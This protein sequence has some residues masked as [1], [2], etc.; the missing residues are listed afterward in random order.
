MF[1]P[2]TLIS[3]Y[4]PAIEDV[5]KLNVSSI[6][7]EIEFATVKPQN[8]KY[9]SINTIS[10]NLNIQKEELYTTLLSEL[11]K[12]ICEG[13]EHS[14]VFISFK[15]C[16]IDKR[17]IKKVIYFLLSDY[18]INHRNNVVVLNSPPENIIDE[19]SD[20]VLALNDALKNYKIHPLPIIDFDENGKD[21][22]VKWLGIYDDSD[23]KKLKDLLFEQYS[24]AQSDF[25]DPANVVGQL[26]DFDTYGNF[27]SNFPNRDDIISF[28]KHENDIVA[29]QQ[30]ESLL[31][32]YDCIKKDDDSLYLCN[33]NYY[34]KE[35]VELSNLLNDKT[36]CDTVSKLLFDKLKLNLDN[37]SNYKF[38]GITTT[39]Q[40]ILKSLETQKLISCD[41]YDP[42]LDNYHSFERDLT[43]EKIDNSKKY[44]LICDVISTGYLTQRLNSRLEKFNTNIEYVA[45]IASILDPNFR[46]T[47][48]FLDEFKSKLFSL[49]EFSIQ[50][51]ERTD[52]GIDFFKKKIVRVNPHT[53]IPIRLSVSET[54]FNESIALHTS[55][56]YSK[57]EN[58]ITVRNEFLNSIDENT[59][60]IGFYRFNNVIHPYF[61]N[62]KQILKELDEK[63]LKRTFEKINNSGFNTEKIKVFF[64]RKS[65]IDELNFK[66]LK[67]VLKNQHIEEIEIERFGTTEGWRFP[68]NTDYFSSK[69][70]DSFCF[71]LDDGSCSGDSLIQMIDEI[72]FYDAKEIVLLCFIGRVND[73]KR[74]FFSR[75]SQI[76][77]K[78]GRNIPISI[79]FV[80][81]WHIPT[82]Y[83]DDNPNT[84]ETNW[85][86]QINNLQN[87]PRIIKKIALSI[88]KEIKPKED[89]KFTDYKY[90][91][92]I[93]G[94]NKIPKKELLIIREE[95][96][97]VIG[98]RLYT[99][100]FTYFDYF[101]RK[102]QQPNKIAN[103]YQD[104]ELICAALVYE[105]YLY[106]KLIHILPDVTERIESFVSKLILEPKNRIYPLLT[107]NWREKD[108]LHL[109]FIVF[110]NEKLV[111]ILNDKSKFIRLIEFS[112]KR[113]S[114][115]NYIL[116][117]LL[118][119]LPL[120]I[121]EFKDKKYDFKIREII[122]SW[123]NDTTNSNKEIKQFYY[124]INSL[125]SRDDFDSQLEVLI[126]N[127]NK[128]KEPEFHVDKISFSH[129][130]S[131]ILAI[132]RGFINNIEEGN[133]LDKDK[134]DSI[135]EMWF[136]IL[137]F[138]NPIISFSK[139]F[140]DYLLPFPYF[141][142]Q[143]IVEKLISNV[144]YNEDVIFSLTESFN[145]SE[146]LKLVEK[147]ILRI[148]NDFK[149][150]S[151]FYN[152]IS[153]RQ[154]NLN[155]LLNS[156]HSEMLAIPK[157]IYCT[158]EDLLNDSYT[159]NLPEVYSELLIRKELI[160]NIKNHSKKGVDSAVTIYYS[161]NSEFELEMKITNIE[162]EEA[163]KNSNGEGI[164]CLNL[165]SDSSLFGFKYNKEKDGIN[166][167]QTL[168]FKI[169]KD[170]NK[171]Y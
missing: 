2:G 28:F 62:T 53:N 92:R 95:L 6:K 79:Y 90:L 138:I 171:K 145:D 96:G 168:T 81:H 44:I 76:K 77:V 86:E 119:Y 128:H 21:L 125:P 51:F 140:R 9:I 165:L 63:I 118:K 139:N 85:L 52:L 113:D 71:I 104:I 78:K 100:N 89:G 35:Y 48:L 49:F 131:F 17:I 105:P 94:T 115:I 8:K 123:K 66:L 162:S 149:I 155:H 102:Y 56:E 154:S 7:P 27:I 47:K 124:F 30:I 5:K 160:T 163:K 22:K 152:L 147:N 19:I 32:K 87:T 157:N 45:V 29:S 73:H 126:E 3:L 111:E 148:Q 31:K 1:F 74:E 14:L 112:Q 153:K 33:G 26:N 151:D 80:C 38:I 60:H 142:L 18:E 167:I 117:N 93:R 50:K 166:F 67:E 106:E 12:K 121:D 159:I 11:K 135:S 141:R 39:S 13:K 25:I 10:R 114:N 34:Q 103:Y 15:G 91:P 116:Y 150:D 55:I 129:N 42:S 99:E 169:H 46:K 146:K 137:N 64:P 136:E 65:G 68:H 158:G 97:K 24:I 70:L 82:Y 57:L 84:R 61:F 40:K 37:L 58:K 36:D 41:Q 88:L 69:I 4:I 127:Y 110:T 43:E 144:G 54:N 130:I 134:I 23:K 72:S 101:I 164:K 16:K 120:T 161:M 143:N 156:I 133:P 132:L 20:E 107:Y 98:Y 109:F 59:I 75:L 170:G 83:L 122:K 108:L